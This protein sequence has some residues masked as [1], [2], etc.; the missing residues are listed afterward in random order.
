MRLDRIIFAGNVM[1]DSLVRMLETARHAALIR[2]LGME[3]CSYGIL[4]LHRPSN[5]DDPIKFGD[6]MRAVA[7]IAEEI[8]IIFPIHPRTALRARDLSIP[9]MHT[10]IQN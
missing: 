1:I 10:W 5:V 6:T 7:K 2:E 3:S 4:T 9:N 8:P